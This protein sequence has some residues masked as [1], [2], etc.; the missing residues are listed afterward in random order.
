[1]AKVSGF[2]VSTNVKPKKKKSSTEEVFEKAEVQAKKR[3]S[4][5]TQA[6]KNYDE[7]LKVTAGKHAG[8]NAPIRTGRVTSQDLAA[9]GAYKG[10]NYS[11]TQKVKG[12]KQTGYYDAKPAVVGGTKRMVKVSKKNVNK[13]QAS[14]QAKR[15]AK[16]LY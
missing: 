15:S 14:K 2:K 6:A 16:K 10:G 9:S 3:E 13:T 8:P 1:M 4:S 11:E 12:L 7:G 5:D